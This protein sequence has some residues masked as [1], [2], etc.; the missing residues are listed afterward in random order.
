LIDAVL[1]RVENENITVL[2]RCSSPSSAEDA[3]VWSCT[4]I[5]PYVFKHSA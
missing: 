5:S 4:S 2:Q 3:N 1:K